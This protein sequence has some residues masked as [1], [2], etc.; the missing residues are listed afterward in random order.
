MIAQHSK[1]RPRRLTK[2]QIRCRLSSGCLACQVFLCVP[3]SAGC[4]VVNRILFGSIVFRID[5]YGLVGNSRLLIIAD[6]AFD[7]TG[8]EDRAFKTTDCQRN[9][10]YNHDILHKFSVEHFNELPLYTNRY[11][12]YSSFPPCQRPLAAKS[13]TPYLYCSHFPGF[14]SR[15]LSCVFGRVNVSC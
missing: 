13:K 12:R 15:V 6:D 2:I 11:L 3:A 9:W 1:V 8:F 4:P 14:L 5:L 10:T 7:R